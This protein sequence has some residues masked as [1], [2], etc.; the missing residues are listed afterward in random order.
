MIR[1]W[2]VS[3]VARAMEPGC[4]VDTALVLLGEQGHKKSSFFAALAP[5]WFGDTEI[6]IG[7][8]D[9]LQQIHHNWITE[10][11]E[12]DRI[13]SVR[14]AGEVKTFI[15]RRRDCFRPPYGMNTRNYERSCVIVGSTNN[16]GFLSDPTGGRRF[17]VIPVTR[18]IDMAYIE[19]VRDQLWAEALHLYRAG[20]QWWLTDEEEGL[21]A[22]DVEQ[23]RVRDPWEEVVSR[24]IEDAWP[25]RSRETRRAHFTT[26]DVMSLA[27]KLDPK[28]AR[29]ETE[30]RVG[31]V[32][33]AL[34][35][36]RGRPS[37]SDT[38][39]YVGRDGKP[40]QRPRVWVRREEPAAPGAGPSTEPAPAA[41]GGAQSEGSGGFV[42][43]SAPAR[44]PTTSPMAAV[45]APPVRVRDH[46][47]AHPAHAPPLGFDDDD[48]PCDL[49]FST[50]DDDAPGAPDYGVLQ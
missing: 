33:R 28:D 27:L 11:A 1:R 39:T 29:K 48:P 36:D 26:W 50:G 44:V 37:R 10:W 13:T 20:D 49:P 22:T 45:Y 31:A 5:K 47:P 38:G 46:G 12:I 40:T 41:D 16:D 35:Y 3:A 23:Y 18:K 4:K 19:L 34:G 9:G 24:W 21:H 30:G 43:G 14:H 17:W 25:T 8:K 2:F 32:M 7:D 15:A 6:K 42:V